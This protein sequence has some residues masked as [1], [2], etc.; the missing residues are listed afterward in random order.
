MI[1]IIS[2]TFH[3]DSTWRQLT[4]RWVAAGAASHAV[5][6]GCD[7]L[8]MGGGEQLF[9]RLAKLQDL[10][11]HGDSLVGVLD[12]LQR[13]SQLHGVMWNMFNNYVRL[14][15]CVTFHSRRH[16][17]T[18]VGET[19]KNN[20]DRVSFSPVFD[21]S[22]LHTAVLY[23]TIVCGNGFTASLFKAKHKVNPLVEVFRHIL[24][25]Q[26]RPVL[27]EEIT[28]ICRVHIQESGNVHT[29]SLYEDRSDIT[30][31]RSS[32]YLRPTAGEQHRRPSFRSAFDLNQDSVC[33]PESWGRSH[34]T[35]ESTAS[36]ERHTGFNRRLPGGNT[37]CAGWQKQPEQIKTIGNR[38]LLL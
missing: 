36:Q 17:H 22:M 24:T 37:V 9:G 12:A 33:F 35:L 5:K 32:C 38:Y 3:N 29:G 27:Q 21:G 7:P 11:Q 16:L 8:G 18:W 20:E 1:L 23:F 34:K 26:S 15:S 30:I 31:R 13:H 25:F 19:L 28:G 2:A 10:R 6:P 14:N 4:V